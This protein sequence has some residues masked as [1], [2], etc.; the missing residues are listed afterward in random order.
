MCI[1]LYSTCSSLWNDDAGIVKWVN[2]IN[3]SKSETVVRCVK[4]RGLETACLLMILCF[5]IQLSCYYIM[6]GWYL[7]MCWR[8]CGM[9]T[10]WKL[11]NNLPQPELSE[12]L[13][14]KQWSKFGVVLSHYYMMIFI[15]FATKMSVVYCLIQPIAK[16]FSIILVFVISVEL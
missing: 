15:Q 4:K 14:D 11:N 8:S 16:G 1:D 9:W 7:L 10:M 12:L 2:T 13:E 3:T 6:I 5:P